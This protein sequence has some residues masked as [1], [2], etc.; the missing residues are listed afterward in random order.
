M[1]IAHPS[2]SIWLPGAGELNFRELHAAR[3]VEEYDAD[4]TLGQDKASGQW[5]VF[6]PAADGHPFPVLGLGH[7]LPAPEQI[8]E[9]L[10]RHD[11]RRN[12]RAIL[13]EMAAHADKSDR[14]F[15]SKVDDANTA[16]SEAIASHMNSEGTHPFP[17]IHMGGKRKK[18]N[19]RSAD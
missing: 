9:L 18:G 5:A 3:A 4:L 2:E 12:G 1:N 6:L 16:V 17:T 8:K 19:V 14:E 15:A 13:A 10:Y 7:E 11:V